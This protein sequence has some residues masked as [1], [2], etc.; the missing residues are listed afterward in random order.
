MKKKIC[1]LGSTGSIGITTLNII[2]RDKKNFNLIL[3]STNNNV[4]KI[5]RQAKEF[6]PK[7]IIILNKKKYSAWKN[8]FNNKKIKVYNNFKQFNKIFKNRVDYTINAISGIDGLEP[9]I[10]IIKHTKKIAIANKESI[11]CG[12]NLI[13]KE[14]KKYRTEFIPVDSEHFSIFKLIQNKNYKYIKK[15]IITASGGPFLNKKTKKNIKISEALKHPNWKMGKKISIDSS[16]MMNKVFEVIEAKKIFNIGYDKIDI[17]INPNSYIHASVIFNDGTIEL[18]A[19]ET[20]MEI[21][22]INSIYGRHEVNYKT[23]NINLKKINDLNLSVP[24]LNKFKTLRILKFLPY[25]DTLFETI[26]ITVNDE[27][28]DMFLNK[29]IKYDQMLL[30]LFKIINFK[31]FKKYCNVSPISID[32]IYKTRNFVRKFVK[33][34]VVKKNV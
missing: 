32:Q 10:K 33:N 14:L 11:I 3:L 31:N 19:H 13:N 1:I 23:K 22:I 29:K 8:R 4:E 24:N 9:T 34:Y 12:W 16:T 6:K 5:Y 18:L 28:V 26:I 7:N 20:K 2:K 27:L 17:L 15:I 21:P 30:Y 25:K